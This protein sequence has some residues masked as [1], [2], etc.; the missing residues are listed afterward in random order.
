MRIVSICP[1]NTE[2]L[3]YLGAKDLL[4][5]VDDFS[6]FPP[7][8]A[9]LPRLGPDLSIHMDLVEELQP[10]LVIASLSVPGME[11]NIK[12]LEERG[13]PHITLNPKSWNNILE[14]VLLVGS[15]IG[16]LPEAEKLVAHLTQTVEMIRKHM[17]T[18]QSIPRI[19]W[20]WWPKP[21]FTPGQGNWLTEV[22]ELVGAYNI[23]ADYL[24]ESVQTN[25]LEVV[26][27]NPDLVMVAWT[28]IEKH[29]IKKDM[30]TTRPDWQ[31]T[32]L[33][34]PNLIQICDEGWFCRPSPRLLVGIKHLAH[35]LAPSR[36]EPAS[37]D[38]WQDPRIQAK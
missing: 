12:Q 21:V 32:P 11:K 13:I 36:F 18:S 9:D 37:E 19:Y 28:G 22:C 2:I 16:R 25:W 5:G 27:R 34:D 8:Y 7:D 38:L 10:D 31:N 17:S 26:K 24:Q 30:F 23:F 33:A 14:D 35:L 3:H 1:S 6:D 20:E 4:V 29:R 15:Y